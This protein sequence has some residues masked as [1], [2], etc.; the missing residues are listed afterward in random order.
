MKQKPNIKTVAARA[1]V[2]ASTVSRYFNGHYVSQSVR[3]R[4]AEIISELG[5]TRSATA[6]NLSLGLKGCFGVV[7]DSTQDPWFTQLLMGIE[8]E[9]A[10]RDTSLMLS[11]LELRGVYDPGIVFT[12][13]REQRV[14]GLILVKSQ[15]RDRA[16]AHAAIQ[17]KLPIVM[18]VPYENLADAQTLHCDN[19]AAGVTVANHLAELGHR[20]I[21]FAGGPGNSL[22]TRERLRGLRDGLAACGLDM[23]DRNVSYCGSFESEAGVRWAETFF[24]SPLNVTAV[25]TGNDALALGVMRVAQQ[26]GIRIPADLSLVGFDN[27]PECALLWP[28]LTTMAQPMREMGKVA[29]QN[30]FEAIASPGFVKTVIYPMQLVVRESSGPVAIKESRRRATR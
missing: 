13:I 3:E 28:G 16:L 23:D 30:L 21:A 22:D 1:G 15:G 5:Y 10:A 29:C 9:L 26:H 7:V 17:A 27:I 20:S 25:V 6:R 4:L 11:S 8:E 2:A 24:N 12:W 14:D 18:V 19:H